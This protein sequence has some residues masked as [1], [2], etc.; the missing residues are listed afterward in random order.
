MRKISGI[1]KLWLKIAPGNAAIAAVSAELIELPDEVDA[2]SRTMLAP[3]AIAWEYSMSRVVS[4]DQP[5]WSWKALCELKFTTGHVEVS[6]GVGEFPQKMVNEG[7][8]GI[9]KTLS[10]VARSLAMPGLPKASTM[11]IV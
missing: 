8:A 1:P 4:T 3:G 2:T 9:L 5:I 11:T 7:G 6:N 10:K